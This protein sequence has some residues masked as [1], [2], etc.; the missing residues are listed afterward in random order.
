M[1]A[2][3]TRMARN[4][5]LFPWF[6]FGQN[7]LFWQSVWFLFF[8]DTL[9]GQDAVLLYSLRELSTTLLEVPT[10]VLSDRL[11]RKWT[12]LLAAATNLA[13]AVLL[14]TGD[15]FLAFAAA[16]ILMGTGEAFSSGADNALLYQS[17]AAARRADEIER[18]QFR[19][20]RFTFTALALSAVSGGALA[21]WDPRAP[22]VATAVATA[23][24]FV[25]VLF[26]REPP[27]ERIPGS[28]SRVS[29]R[30]QMK[31]LRASFREPV[32]FWLFALSVLM[33]GFGHLPFVF[34]QPFIFQ[35]LDREGLGL[36]APLVSGAVSAIMMI[37]SVG[38]SH[39]V[40][41]LRGLMG[42]SG[43][44]LF[45][46][47]MQIWLVGMLALSDAAILIALLFLRMVPSSL[48]GPLVLARVQPLLHDDS[49]ATYLSVQSLV[50]RLVFALA[51]YVA[52]F[53]ATDAAA[54][55][56]PEIRVI[57]SVFFA[58]GVV[59]LAALALAS[60]RVRLD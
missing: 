31:T 48:A 34:G 54:M 6:K 15:A 18:Q 51:L 21:L 22:F 50:G 39:L 11:G 5:A 58:V 56:F 40:P 28:S 26:M 41:G 57:L 30:G 49:R 2:D 19:A 12:L 20:W 44:L 4:I 59:C 45:A 46:F 10:G 36:D 1:S 3:G 53:G 9:S 7:L 47:A 32:L 24:L 13:G 42:T 23:V 25:L 16:Q 43:L 35:A 37:V 27:H 8:Q 38:T 33:Y 29:V 55:S 52:A 17:L 60:R 14:A